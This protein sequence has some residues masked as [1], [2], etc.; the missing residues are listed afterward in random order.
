MRFEKFKEIIDLKVR[1]AQRIHQS[2]ELGIDLVNFFDE[3]DMVNSL[4]W[5][6]ILTT[7]GVGWLNWFL[8]EKGY[9]HDGVGRENM[10]AWDVDKNEIC[11]D[12]VSLYEMLV[13]E[14]Y[15]KC[16]S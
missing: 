4:L 16:K 15:F 12:L 7:E 2:Y 11:K 10:K 14:G 6:E 9:I 3:F 8:Y 5:E 1:I 13:K